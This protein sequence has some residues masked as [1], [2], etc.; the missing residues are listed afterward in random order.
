M[1]PLDEKIQFMVDSNSGQIAMIIPAPFIVFES[2]EDYEHFLQT[3]HEALG[4]LRTTTA[5][6]VI[7]KDYASEVIEHWQ[8]ELK[9]PLMDDGLPK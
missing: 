1:E 8:A 9:N 4:S 7:D 6:G 5:S 2:V 3:L